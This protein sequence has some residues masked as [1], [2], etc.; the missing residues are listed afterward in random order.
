MKPKTH[1]EFASYLMD[2]YPG[3]VL[4]GI[5]ERLDGYFQVHEWDGEAHVEHEPLF[6]TLRGAEVF[7]AKRQRAHSRTGARTQGYRWFQA[8]TAPKVCA[9]FGTLV[10]E[11]LTEGELTAVIGMRFEDAGEADASALAA[12][13]KARYL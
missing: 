12:L 3:R 4:V 7:K 6:S 8:T 5:V 9:T 1:G 2:Q 13:A 11:S 10:V